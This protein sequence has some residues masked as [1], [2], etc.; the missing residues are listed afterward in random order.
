MAP[1]TKAK[2]KAKLATLK[3]G[4]GY[5]DRWRDYSALE[6]VAGDAYGNAERAELFEYRTQPRQARPAGRPLRVG[7]DAADGQRGEPA[8][9]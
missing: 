1:A 4:V 9:A 7:D 2:A 6:V 5:P 3:V 8:G